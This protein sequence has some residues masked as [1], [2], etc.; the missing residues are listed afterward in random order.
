MQC[1]HT[2]LY[3]QRW[4][5]AI[6]TVSIGLWY[7][8]PGTHYQVHT[9]TGTHYQE[10]RFEDVVFRTLEQDAKS[11]STEWETAC[12]SM[13]G[14]FHFLSQSRVNHCKRHTSIISV[15]THN[16]WTTSY[17]SPRCC[18]G[19]GRFTDSRDPCLDDPFAPLPFMTGSTMTSQLIMAVVCP[20]CYHS[21]D[22][23]CYHSSDLPC[24]HSSDL[25]SDS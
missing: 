13:P 14:F 5:P 8:L 1:A 23:P 3:T 9:T 24:Y 17:P 16:F 19:G 4:S 21:S 12:K 20:V 18:G 25:P 6:L 10:C 11:H 7:T 22:L 15:Q 2:V